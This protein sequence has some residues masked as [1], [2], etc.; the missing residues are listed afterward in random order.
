MGTERTVPG[1]GEQHEQRHGWSKCLGGPR[2]GEVFKVLKAGAGR[3]AGF[4]VTS[5]EALNA[6]LGVLRLHC[7]G[8]KE[9]PKLSDQGNS[10]VTSVDG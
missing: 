3:T 9:S 10:T 4:E 8:S 7:V 5:Q 1:H 6:M 2:N